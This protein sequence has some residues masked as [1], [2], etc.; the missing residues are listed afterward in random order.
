[1]KQT[2]LVT[3]VGLLCCCFWGVV[4]AENR[5]DDRFRAL[6]CPNPDDIAP[7]V[8]TVLPTNGMEMDCSSVASSIELAIV[9]S[10]EF[11]FKD[12]ESLIII[13]NYAITNLR[14]GDFGD[15]TFQKITIMSGSLSTVVMNTFMASYHT[16]TDLTITGTDLD[17]FPFGELESFT[18][19]IYLDLQNNKLTGFPTLASLT[20][21]EL[22][23]GYNA[24]GGISA[25]SLNNL[26]SLVIIGLHSTSIS[27]IFPGTYSVSIALPY[28]LLWY[29]KHLHGKATV[30]KETQSSE[31]YKEVLSVSLSVY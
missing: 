7:C 27:Q 22:L 19:L 5:T 15:V 9:F 11:P 8:C 28:P 2:A 3:W 24:L 29:T 6:P 31:N 17:F 4:A 20:L 26:P 16:L 21:R 14:P 30:K 18:K 25:T 23:L 12:F 10:A 13:N 1:M